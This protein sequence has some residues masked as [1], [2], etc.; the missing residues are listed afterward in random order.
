M[1][2]RRLSMHHGS[3]KY[4]FYSIE[5]GCCK[6]LQQALCKSKSKWEK[7]RRMGEEWERFGHRNIT[8]RIDVSNEEG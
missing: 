4:L 3:S 6:Y 7:E 1:E 5:K 2:P 8:V